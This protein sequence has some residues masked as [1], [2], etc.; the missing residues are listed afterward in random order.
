MFFFIIGNV[1]NNVNEIIWD[2]Y[3]NLIDYNMNEIGFLF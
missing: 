1:V 2:D 3:G